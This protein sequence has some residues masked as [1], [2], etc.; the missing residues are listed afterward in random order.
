LPV[1]PW[2]G[3][4]VPVQARLHRGLDRLPAGSGGPRRGRSPVRVP[5][6]LPERISWR[7]AVE[8]LPRFLRRL[9]E[10]LLTVR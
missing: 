6:P 7:H 1:P 8:M 9:D 3:A 2:A 4:P 5:L 10:T